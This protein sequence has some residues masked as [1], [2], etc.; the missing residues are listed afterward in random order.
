MRN[1]FHELF[2]TKGVNYYKDDRPLQEMLDFFGFRGSDN[3]GEMGSYV[4]E[5]LVE[6]LDFIDHSARP[7]LHTWGVMGERIDYVRLS[8]DH[9]RALQKLQEFGVIRSIFEEKRSIMQHFV[10]GYIISDSGIFCTLTLTAQTA[11]AVDK[12]GSE[13]IKRK[14][15]GRFTDVNEPWYGATFYTET[16]GGSDL[17]ANKTVALREDGGYLI[18]GK[19]KYFASDAGIADASIV[20]ARL[21]GSP[22]GA[23][24]ISV[25]MVPAYRDDGKLNYNI[26]RLKDK[27]GTVAVPTGEV[28]FDNALG[29]RLGG[30]REGIYIAMEILTISR[31]DDAIAAVGI[32]RKSIWEAYRYAE[33]R[34]AFGKTLIDHPLMIR[35]LVEMEVEL[36]A[37]LVLSLLSSHLF[38][39]SMSKRPPYD[40]GYQ[41][42]RALSSIAK[43]MAAES[44]AE[45][46][47]Y[48]ME[49]FGG[50][51]FLEEFPVAK[52]HRDS[53]V[54]S[55]WEGT[56]NIQA[57]ELLEVLTRK[58]GMETVLEHL[59][60]ETDR[61]VSEEVRSKLNDL[62]EKLLNKTEGVVK[63]GN[64]EF[65]AKDL[66]RSYG[67]LIASIYL[68]RVSEHSSDKKSKIGMIAEQYFKR[69]LE[70]KE[71]EH[72]E[73]TAMLPSIEWMSADAFRRQ[74]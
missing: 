43:N 17:G 6:L 34:T 25:F 40:D 50:S 1:L 67:E 35:D 38:N 13:D 16:Q 70:G 58:N 42:A 65:Y 28:E 15:L 61:I 57:L 23:K 47:R 55:I 8:P 62:I 72:G 45:I 56:S 7:V 48:A 19:D 18:S 4:S 64:P 32:A 36:E 11:Y 51:G 31:I 73:I 2:L 14:Y 20:T 30:D 54:T 33:K 3:L 60:G 37:S 39:R 29:Y 27:L 12:Y 9:A 66:L 63:S 52:F 59:K 10:S 5:E 26:R 22:P 71:P 21:E 44:S 69:H 49:I 46:T 53:I 24:G 68:Y 74:Q 41:L